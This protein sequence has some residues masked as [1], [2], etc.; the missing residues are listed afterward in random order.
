MKKLVMLLLCGGLL[1]GCSSQY[2]IKVSD[3]SLKLASGSGLDISKQEY[4]EYLLDTYGA[5]AVLSEVL[6]SIADKE[7]TDQDKIDKLLQ[8]RI[9]IYTKY[10]GGDLKQYATS[11]GY[12]DENEYID[13]TL[14]PDVKQELLRNKYIEEHFDDLVNEYEISCLKKIIVDKESKALSIIKDST[15]EE[16]FDKIMKEYGTDGE[17]AGIVTNKSALD[18]NLKKMLSKFSKIDK[19]GIYKDAIELSNGNYA[20]VYLYDTEKKDKE[21]YI[22]SLTSIDELKTKIEGI[23]LKKYNFKVYDKKLENTIK[24]FSDEYIE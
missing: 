7:V 8:E 13:T 6:T 11:L 5:D 18:E 22:Q 1:V 15:S 4:F 2:S 10:G 14:L 9:E 16:A 20:V 23:Y 12:K 19:D 21:D 24:D 3:P 17:D